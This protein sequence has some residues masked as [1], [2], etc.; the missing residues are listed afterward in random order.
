MGR[1]IGFGQRLAIAGLLAIALGGCGNETPQ[2]LID[3]ARGFAAKGD[4]KAAAIQLRNL[5][6]KQ[7]EYAEA[8]YLL[9]RALNEEMDYV[10]AEKELRKALEYGYAPNDVYPALARAMLGQSAGR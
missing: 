8:R 10:S 5:L 9:G 4:H 1:L 2:A 3:S 7:P 6:Q